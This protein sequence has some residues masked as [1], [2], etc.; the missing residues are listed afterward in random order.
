MADFEVRGAEDIDRLV[1]AI[2]AHADSKALRKELYSGLAR[3]TKNVKGPM[4]E[5]IPAALPK[6][7]GL[8]AEVKSSTRVRISPRAGRYAGVRM[9]FASSK[10]DIRTLVGK[11][12]RHPVYGNRERWVS[13]TAGVSPTVFTF[14][15]EHQKPA[16]RRAIIGVMNDVARKVAGS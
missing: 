3:V 10:H 4:I 15:F 14:A 1:R 8:A 11:R 6:R 5:V 13:Q 9:R 16:V 7:G 2:R 12:L